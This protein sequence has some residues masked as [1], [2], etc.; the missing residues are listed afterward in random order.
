MLYGSD[1]LVIFYLTFHSAYW[2][3]RLGR[4]D[5]S[6]DLAPALGPCGVRVPLSKD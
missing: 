5:D 1:T 3:T 4:V 2:Y 6:S